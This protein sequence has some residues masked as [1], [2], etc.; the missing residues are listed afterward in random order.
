MDGELI[1]LQKKGNIINIASSA[2]LKGFAH[3]TAYV[4][5]K[6][7]LRGMT[8]CWKDE[9]REH[10][11]KVMLVNPSEVQTSFVINSGREG[12]EHNSTIMEAKEIILSVNIFKCLKSFSNTFQH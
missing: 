6:F 2:A 4:A 8:E 12:R 10:N 3:G 9:L 1:L 11:I 7:A 5:S